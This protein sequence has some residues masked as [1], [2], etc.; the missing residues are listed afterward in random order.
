MAELVWYRLRALG[1]F[2]GK[3]CFVDDKPILHV[4][5][6]D[7][8]VEHVDFNINYTVRCYN[9]INSKPAMNY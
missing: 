6:H 2:F 4:K 3:T 1:Y 5:P 7:H 9:H 8:A